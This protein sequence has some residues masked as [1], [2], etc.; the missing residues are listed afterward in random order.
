MITRE[1]QIEMETRRLRAFQRQADDVC[2]LILSTDL[3]RVDVEIRI[4]QLREEARRLFPGKDRL[5]DLVYES[6]FRRLWEQWRNNKE[7]S[8]E[9][10]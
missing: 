6:R 7:V 4:E 8:D 10:G 2:R 9:R 1:W 5:F 3:P